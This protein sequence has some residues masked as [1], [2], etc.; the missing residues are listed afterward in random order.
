[1][2]H[3][4]LRFV[5]FS[6]SQSFCLTSFFVIL[7]FS[8]MSTSLHAL[9]IVLCSPIAQNTFVFQ[10]FFAYCGNRLFILNTNSFNNFSLSSFF[11]P[12]ILCM[13]WF[14]STS[15]SCFW[16]VSGL[17]LSW[18][19][20]C[21]TLKFKYTLKKSNTFLKKPLAKLK[22]QM[23]W[24]LGWYSYMMLSKLGTSIFLRS[25]VL[26]IHFA[27]LFS[28]LFLANCTKKNKT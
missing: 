18:V 22:A 6:T 17:C 19:V 4:S 8:A 5:S 28:P 9:W 15:F 7:T 21:L 16:S 23:D 3:S 27:L 1:M 25:K 20:Y 10:L 26:F 12:L 24:F 2:I 13:A 14:Y 11:L